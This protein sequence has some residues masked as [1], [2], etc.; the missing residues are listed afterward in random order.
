[1][2][3]VLNDN[4][5]FRYVRTSVPLDQFTTALRHKAAASVLGGI[6]I[7]ALFGGLVT[8][9]LNDRIFAPTVKKVLDKR[10]KPAQNESAQTGNEQF[11]G[12]RAATA[13]GAG[14]ITAASL[15]MNAS[16]SPFINTPSYAS[17]PTTSFIPPRAWSNALGGLPR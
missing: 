10:F 9:W 1:M 7:S 16:T 14:A 3:K 17:R 8:Q 15:P 2:K 12:P 13:L 11:S 4:E 6:A 5:L